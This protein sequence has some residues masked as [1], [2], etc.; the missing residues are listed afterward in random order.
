VYMNRWFYLDH[1]PASGAENMAWDE[2]LFDRAGRLRDSPVLRLYRFDPPAVTIGYH[3]AP[4]AVLDVDSLCRG[5]VDLVRRITGG[6]ALLHE[7]ELTY[8]VVTPSCG[9]IFKDGWADAFVSISSA[10]VEALRSLGVDAGLSGGKHRSGVKGLV[11]PC[12]ASSGR[13]EITVRGRKVVGSAQ[14]R[15]RHAILQH[16]SI[17]LVPGSERITAYLK[18]DWDSIRERITSVF[19]ECGGA[20]G[21]REVRS[22]VKEAFAASFY[23]DFH[24]FDPSPSEREEVRRRTLEKRLE[25]ACVRPAEVSLR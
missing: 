7:G 20:V 19:E 15:T 12:L 6:R 16:G 4:D 23:A 5:G 9:G 10:I 24:P 17:L 18:G 21:E 8:C 2:F 11:P 14:R 25:F 13:Y 1:E 22:A 3:Q